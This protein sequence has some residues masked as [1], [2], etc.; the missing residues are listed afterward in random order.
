MNDWWNQF[1]KKKKKEIK[2]FKV[3]KVCI[4]YEVAEYM[5]K[6]NER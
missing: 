3:E 6:I 4:A 2:I 5:E 1:S